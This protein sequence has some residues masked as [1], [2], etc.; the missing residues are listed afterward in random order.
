MAVKKPIAMA[1]GRRKCAVARVRMF[2]GT[3]KITI[4]GRDLLEFM[5]LEA[6]IAF[7]KQPLVLTGLAGSY[8]FTATIRGGGSMG[9]AGAL[10]HGI[11]RCLKETNPETKAALKQAGMLTRDS[12]VKERKKP[13]Q[14]GARKRFQ[15]SKR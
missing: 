15:F 14:P 13:G 5:K 12:R 3:G 7:L 6:N 8:D 4:N 2:P 10:R 9:Q 11:G 1:V